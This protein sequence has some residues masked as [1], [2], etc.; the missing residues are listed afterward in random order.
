MKKITPSEIK[1]AIVENAISI[2]RKRE[3]YNEVKRINN[4]LKSLNE[5]MGIAGSYGFKSD[6]DVMNKSKNGFKDD[7]FQ[8]ISH[9]AELADEMKDEEETEEM[10]E[11]DKLKKENEK[12]KKALSESR[13]KTAIQK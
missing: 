10:S 12:L 4:E 5:G 6:D 2:K 1:K 9:I 13:K 7:G 11:L 3:L 8:N